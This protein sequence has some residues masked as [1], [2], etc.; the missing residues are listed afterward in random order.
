MGRTFY[1]PAGGAYFS[2]LLKNAENPASAKNL[3]V[4]AAVSA[5]EAIGETT[6][7]DIGI[8]WVNDLYFG[9]KKIAGI[10]CEA[11]TEGED[12]HLI[13]GVGINVVR[14]KDGYPP[15]I[16]DRA[17]AIS[18]FTTPPDVGELIASVAPRICGFPSRLSDGEIVDRYRKR[19][20]V[21]GKKIRV[22]GKEVIRTA[23]ALAICDDA[24]LL[25]EYEDGSREKLD[26]GDISI[27]M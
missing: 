3:T 19:S 26:R 13:C 8:K 17:A 15:E 4:Y 24:S 22:A 25:V 6:G 9:G 21:C 23:T 27:I 7:L 11:V 18:D 14:P 1:S 2:V 5:A 20:F 16:E 10:L 12:T